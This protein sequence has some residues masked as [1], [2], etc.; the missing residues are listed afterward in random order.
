MTYV[1]F[2]VSHSHLVRFYLTCVSSSNTAYHVLAHPQTVFYYGSVYYLQNYYSVYT[3]V[4]C[5]NPLRLGLCSMLLTALCIVYAGH[6]LGVHQCIVVVHTVPSLSKFSSAR[7]PKSVHQCRTVMFLYKFKILLGHT[8]MQ[9][10]VFTCSLFSFL[11]LLLTC[12]LAIHIYC[13]L[14]D[15]APNGP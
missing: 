8:V 4:I 1:H 13:Q 9:V 12:I 10:Y 7:K 15:F 14:R 2:C 6:G 3:A 11:S 5:I